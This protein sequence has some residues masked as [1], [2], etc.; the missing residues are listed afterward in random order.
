MLV[1]P[2]ESG[3]AV[4]ELADAAVE[5]EEERVV[6]SDV[7][8]RHGQGD[9]TDRFEQGR[10]LFQ[11]GFHSRDVAAGVAP[12][13]GTVRHGAQELLLEGGEPLPSLISKALVIFCIR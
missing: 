3:L 1:L 2:V 9:R 11:Q 4:V 13:G 8:D 10:P 7:G 5:E 12:A 6:G